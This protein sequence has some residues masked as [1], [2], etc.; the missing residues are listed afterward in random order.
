[1]INLWKINGVNISNEY[2]VYMLKGSYDNLLTLPST[3]EYLTEQ[4]R[5]IHGEKAYIFDTRYEA[6]DVTLQFVMSSDDLQ[7]L[8]ERRDSFLS[9]ICGRCEL[10]LCRHNRFYYL[11]YKSTSN[12]SRIT[13]LNDGSVYVKFSITFRETDPSD[14]REVDYLQAE[15]GENI[16]TELGEDILIMNT[17]KQN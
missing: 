8:M 7:H 4:T 3:K 16:T 11:Y 6:R 12:W 15:T 9:F 10:E 13:R 2:G 5:E 17:I 14:V 1:M